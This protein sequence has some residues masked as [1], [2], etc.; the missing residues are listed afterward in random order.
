MITALLLVVV[1]LQVGV[2]YFLWPKKSDTTPTLLPDGV[3]LETLVKL[4]FADAG[5]NTNMA[6]EVLHHV[7]RRAGV[8]VPTFRHLQDLVKK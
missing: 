4:A 2:L 1:V 3:D 7:G 5:I 6:H 8:D